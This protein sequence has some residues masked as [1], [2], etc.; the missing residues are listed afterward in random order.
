MK[1]MLLSSLLVAGLCAGPLVAQPAPQAEKEN[2]DAKALAQKAQFLKQQFE[3]F[4]ANM[5]EVAELLEETE[6]ET[7]KILRQTVE[8]AQ[9]E[10][11][12]EK[13]EAVRQALREGLD[14]AAEKSQGE[15]VTQLGQMLRIL[16]G[17][18]VEKSE[19]DKKLQER[20]A[21]LQE[22]N[23]LL[24]QERKEEAK[25]RAA[26]HAE[27]LDKQTRELMEALKALAQ[28]Q[29]ALA[30]KTAEL[31]AD[32][33]ALRKLG[34]LRNQLDELIDRQEKMN[35][36]T[37]GAPL[38]KLPVL[39]EAQ[40]KLAQASQALGEAVAEAS[41]DEKLAQAISDAGGK[42]DVL[43]DAEEN[44]A[45]A[46]KEMTRAAE[47]LGRSHK[48][49]AD[50]PQKQASADLK[51]ARRAID[52]AMG[53]LAAETPTGEIAGEQDELAAEARALD[54][55]AKAIAEQ[56]AIDPES[57][58]KGKP[59]GDLNKAAGHMNAA[60]R[61]VESQEPQAAGDEQAKALAELRKKMEQAAELRER[62]MEKARQELD[63]E[64]QEQI[65]QD[66]NN[67]AERMKEGTDGKA[68]GGQRSVAQ[69]G[70]SAAGA[71]GKM[72][73]GQAG[74]ANADQNDAIEKLKQAQQQL[75][76]EI[77]ELQERSKQEKL[78]KVEEKLEVILEKQKAITAATK[79]TW[80]NRRSG[81][82]PYDR[83][84]EQTLLDGARKEGQLSEDVGIV[85]KML[86]DEGS[87]VIFPEILG[88]VKDDLKTLQGRLAEKDP[89]LVTQVTQQEVERTLQ[90]L[91]NAVRKEL[92][93]GPG[94]GRG[95]GGGGGG[96]QAPLIPPVAELRML[97]L[98]QQRVLAQTRK[99]EAGV[100]AN[101]V[102]GESV[103][104]ESKVLSREQKR[105][106]KLAE[107]INKKMAASGSG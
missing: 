46:G 97:L 76:E 18:V 100:K 19:T 63:A 105:I 8:H 9:R 80:E 4:L 17:G 75:G 96:Q 33:E 77:A 1:R 34:A 93:K 24:E 72:A 99:L 83:E 70:K 107:E 31:P 55:K 52:E 48:G 32:D 29:E 15:V 25:T 57:L 50:L 59:V 95:G 13:M 56:A 47:A 5:L 44:V 65:A 28:Q 74:P 10:L 88:D 91:I 102:T 94:R 78:A 54:E 2:T 89:G 51:A 40:K 104:A 79:N 6:P 22:V 61:K 64:K 71:A 82:S 27:E 41:R 35:D 98:K 67:L 92:S 30:E 39:S 86:V 43:T 60:S 101:E 26:A 42:P 66:T 7:A 58:A 16:E 85:R 23:R 103:A 87:T 21:A 38:G 69:A 49:D 73:D 84:A 11:V 106:K 62:A 36:Q 37:A 3:E 90:E 81:E 45:A 12:A 14:Q 68:M 53:K 20:Q